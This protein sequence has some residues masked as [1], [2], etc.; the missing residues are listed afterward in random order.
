[1]SVGE[2]VAVVLAGFAAGGINAVV[3]S[4]SLIVFPTLLLVGLSPLSANVSNSIGLVPGG[5]TAS[6][7]YRSELQG[8]S[9]TL[10]RLAPLSFVGSIVGA[11][12]L[13]VLPPEAFETIVP[14]LIALALVLVIAGPRLQK[15]GRHDAEGGIGLAT[16]PGWRA[17]ALLAGT[18]VAG[19]Y[20]GY[21]GAAQGVLVMGIFSAL[22]TEPLQRLNG[23]KNVLTLIVNLVAAATFVIFAREAIDWWVVLMVSVGSLVGGVVGARYG[24]RIPAAVLRAL[25]VVIGL[26][27]IVKL[28]AFP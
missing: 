12:L 21:F 26:V 16:A 20:G 14:I 8:A 11:G 6:L 17:W 19:M 9:A 7:G 4:G 1:M 15:L 5:V 24:R 18:F 22:S 2:V 27:A 10:R 25:I 28:V 23:Y 13:L 3:G